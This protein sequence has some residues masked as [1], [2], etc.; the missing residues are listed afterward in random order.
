MRILHIHQDY[1]DGRPYPFTKAV[2]N[3][4]DAA[5]KSDNE[6]THTVLSI[7]RTSNPFR[8]SL[9]EF[10]SGYSLIYWALPISL[11]YLPTMWLWS[12]FLSFKLPLDNIDL[13]HGHK[14]T[15]EGLMARYL[16]KH[17]SKYFVLSA[18]GGSDSHNIKRLK[19]ERKAFKRNVEQAKHVF[20]VS[21]WFKKTA[22][23]QL[24]VQLTEKSSKLAN[25][26]EIDDLSFSTG[27][28]HNNTYFT[29]LS[30]HQYKRKGIIPLLTAIS[31]LNTQGVAIKLHIYGSGS[32][33]NV[34]AISDVIQK[35][36]L[37]NKVQLKGHIDHKQLL[38]EMH[39]YKGMLLPSANETFGMAY[40]E[41][42]V[43]G[44]VILFHENT[45]VDGFFDD[46]CP[47]VGV[48]NQSTSSILCGIKELESNYDDYYSSVCD[49]QAQKYLSMFTGKYIGKHYVEIAAQHFK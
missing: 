34:A 27:R 24:D 42:L 15:T 41:A 17:L 23:S 28:K 18:R 44:N 6:I 31:E 48:N 32:E 45:G 22:E 13:V 36:E 1:P 46:V 19:F 39:E 37:S 30:F 5:V 40:I 9:K 11:I 49:M 16:A 25:I 3:L 8:V 2:S 12:V 47:G 4:I 43:T 21:P 33:R 7:N 10:E 29:V 35:N 26:C 20:W 14:L 38:K